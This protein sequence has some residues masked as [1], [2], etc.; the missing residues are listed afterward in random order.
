MHADD[1]GA[2][3][4]PESAPPGNNDLRIPYLLCVE[5]SPIASDAGR[6]DEVQPKVIC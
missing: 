1:I 5:S 4:N 6:D 3:R 2:Q